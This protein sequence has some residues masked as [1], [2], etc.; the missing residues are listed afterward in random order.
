[1]FDILRH[2]K[3]V[4]TFSL[5]TNRAPISDKL[6]SYGNFSNIEEGFTITRWVDKIM[7]IKLHETEAGMKFNHPFH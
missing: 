3:C 1:M 4:L 2:F 6:L 5:L 7:E